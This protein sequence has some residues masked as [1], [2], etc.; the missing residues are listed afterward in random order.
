MWGHQGWKKEVM[1][2]S[3]RPA[4][5]S[6][7]VVAV[8]E[9]M[10]IGTR[11]MYLGGVIVPFLGLIAAIALTW[12]R[13]FSWLQLGLL[14]GMYISTAT[15]IAVGYHRLFTHRA[16]ETNPVVKFILAALGAMAAEGTVSQWVAH[17]RKHHQLSDREGDPHSP[18]LHGNGFFEMLGGLWHAHI[19]WFF[20][21]DSPTIQ[22]YSAD[23][24]QDR[25]IRFVDRLGGTWVVIGLLIPAVLGGIIGH[26]WMEALMGL[27]W[28]G[29]VRV[30]FVHHVTWSIN[31]VCHFWGSQDFRTP[32]QSRNNLIFGIV[33]CGEGWHNNHHAFPNS[34]RHGL[35]WWQ[36]DINYLIIRAMALV[37]LAWNIKLP[38]RENLIHKRAA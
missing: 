30:F 34:A 25:V 26:S 20:D 23:L 8:E 10:P 9:P 32:D 6:L 2:N 16:F 12:H 31:S 17:H 35:R 18:H 33:G 29:L 28:G 14:V 24:R 1:N 21:T 7:P 11:I 38:S 5:Q 4:E 37:G 36:L 3:E 27:I 19:G 22:R 15:G 13:G